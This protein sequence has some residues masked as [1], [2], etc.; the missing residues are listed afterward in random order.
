VPDTALAPSPPDVEHLLSEAE[1][2][3][4]VERPIL[5]RGL[6]YSHEAMVDAIIA[7]PGIHQNALAR[8]FGYTPSWISTVLATDAFQAQLA[9]RREEIVDPVLRATAEEQTRG[10][11]L[12]SLEI[13]REKMSADSENVS[14]NLALAVFRDSG[15]LL[16]YG[17]RPPEPPSRETVAEGLIRHADNLVSLLRQKKAEV[18]NHDNGTNGCT[19]GEL[20]PP[21][22]G[23]LETDTQA[24]G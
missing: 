18:F 11:Y 20:L 21:S 8:M 23:K 16:G 4:A 3:P 17:A 10:L 1:N 12:R 15:K 6:N 19:D 9:A 14:D 5:V 2:L 22:S 13:L 7:N 24:K